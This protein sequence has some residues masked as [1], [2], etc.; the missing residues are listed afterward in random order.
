MFTQDISRLD[1]SRGNSKEIIL[2]GEYGREAEKEV[3]SNDRNDFL[4]ASCPSSAKSWLW[5]HEICQGIDKRTSQDG[6]RN[7][8]YHAWPFG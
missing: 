1:M 7:L 3:L 8:I 4:Y 5:N 2:E 6:N